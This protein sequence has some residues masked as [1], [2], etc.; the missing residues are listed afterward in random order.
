MVI[1]AKI[2]SKRKI[3][4]PL[5]VMVCLKLNQGDHLIFEEKDGHVEVKRQIEKF[6]IRDF[7][8]NRRKQVRRKLSDEEIYKARQEA[9]QASESE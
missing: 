2:S 7:V 4:V 8:N 9:W 6:T 3:T 1:V 5:R